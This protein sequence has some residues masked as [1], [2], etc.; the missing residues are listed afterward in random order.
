MRKLQIFFCK[1]HAVS[2]YGE[3]V[4]LFPIFDPGPLRMLQIAYMPFGMRHQP[5]YAPRRVTNTGDIF[6]GTIGVIWVT[7]F[8]SARV[9]IFKHDHSIALQVI[10]RLIIPRYELPLSVRYRQVDYFGQVLGPYAF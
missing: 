1:F 10:Q 6:Y 9:C 4:T 7:F 2:E 3:A 5:E 8:I